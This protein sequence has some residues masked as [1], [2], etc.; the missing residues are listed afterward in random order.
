MNYLSVV[1]FVFLG[2]GLGSLSRFG[3]SK[4]GSN[5]L[6]TKFPI[7]TL[8]AN[9]LACTIL[10]LTLY[11]LKDKV[12]SSHFIKYFIVIGFCGGFSTFS[13]FSAETVN[14]FKDGLFTFGLLNII[15]SM[16]LAFIVLWVLAK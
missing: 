7:G 14:L 3:I 6:D 12:D 9:V 1:L 10:G 11:Y 15:V 2:G 8:V 13:T 5:L 16:G 4:L